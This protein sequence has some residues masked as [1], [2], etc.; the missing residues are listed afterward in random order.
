MD[1]HDKASTGLKGFDQAI[2]KLRLGDNVVWQ[3]DSVDNYKKMVEP[4]VAQAKKDQRKLIY[5]RFGSHERVLEDSPDIKVYCIDAKKGF[6]SFATA[7]HTLVEQEG[8]KVFYVFDCL[9]DLLEYWYSGWV[10]GQ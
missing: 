2:D 9:T 6:E 7:V 3:V 5:V 10:Q 1:I 4:Y 8:K